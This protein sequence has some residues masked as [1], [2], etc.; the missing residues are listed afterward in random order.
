MPRG[1]QSYAERREQGIG[2]RRR[3]RLVAD[4][5]AVLTPAAVAQPDRRHD[6]A[7]N[8]RLDGQAQLR[9]GH[10]TPEGEAGL[11]CGPPLASFIHWVKH[12][13][14]DDASTLAVI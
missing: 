7:A 4:Q 3:R 1:G 8:R 12:D 5:G 14:L 2:R 11:G 13:R 6:D 10:G 9:G